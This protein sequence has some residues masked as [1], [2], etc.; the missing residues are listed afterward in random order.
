MGCWKHVFQPAAQGGDGETEARV[1][2]MVAF[3]TAS[4]GS[5]GKGKS[6]DWV[7]VLGPFPSKPTT[8]FHQVKHSVH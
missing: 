2:T 1:S 8:L 3:R 6:L 7:G 5:G 4:E